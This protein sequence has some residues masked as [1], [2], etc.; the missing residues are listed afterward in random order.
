MRFD[1]EGAEKSNASSGSALGA[2]KR[3]RASK[4]SRGF[5]SKIGDTRAS[6]SSIAAP[7]M[8]SSFLP[9]AFA[10]KR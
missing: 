4:R 6:T 1:R 5:H 2:G 10:Q 7:E 8:L 9:C 3:K